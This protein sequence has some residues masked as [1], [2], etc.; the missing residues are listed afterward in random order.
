MLIVIEMVADSLR[1]GM[2]SA[3]ERQAECDRLGGFGFVGGH[4]SKAG[5][6]EGR[7]ESAEKMLRGLLDEAR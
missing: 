6:L 4:A 2:A 3:N 7:C 5:I 1:A